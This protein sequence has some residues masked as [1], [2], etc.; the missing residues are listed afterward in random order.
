MANADDQPSSPA[1]QAGTIHRIGGGTVENLRLKSREV[2]L[3]VPGISVIKAST[4]DA[5]AQEIRAGFP[6]A[7]GL[8]QQAKMIGSASEAA[9]RSVGFDVIPA[10][11]LALPNH[12][13]IVHPE[14]V[15]GFNET[16][17]GRLAEVFVNTTGLGS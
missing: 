13:R 12:H 6:R 2:T 16:N 17:L 15:N 7:T 9:I 11:S 10:P 8:H 5:A 14:G 4:P 3:D 1:P